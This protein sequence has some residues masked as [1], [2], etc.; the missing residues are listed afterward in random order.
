[1]TASTDSKTVIPLPFKGISDN[2]GRL[3]PQLARTGAAL[4]FHPFGYNEKG[5][6]END[7]IILLFL[8]WSTSSWAG[9]EAESE[10]ESES[11]FSGQ[12]RSRSRIKFFDSAALMYR[13]SIELE[14]CMSAEEVHMLDK[15]TPIE[16]AS[17]VS[18]RGH[19]TVVVELR[20]FLRLEKGHA[21]FQFSCHGIG[22]PEL[23]V[24]GDTKRPRANSRSVQEHRGVFKGG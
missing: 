9:V 19:C 13:S 15:R 5:N 18:F 8:G 17:F 7:Y 4:S 24:T 22:M 11:I 16:A 14:S 6:Q 12:S 23:F 3:H 20:V 21:I 10:L 1:M 2:H